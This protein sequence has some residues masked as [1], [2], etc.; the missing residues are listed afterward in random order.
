A[1]SPTPAAAH[2]HPVV[3]AAS[4]FPSGTAAFPGFQ[5]PLMPLAPD[6]I[7]AANDSVKLKTKTFGMVL[8]AP[9]VPTVKESNSRNMGMSFI[10]AGLFLLFCILGLRF[11]NN[12]KYISALLHN[13]V[14]VRERSNV[15]DETVRET[16]FIVLLNLLWSCSAGIVLCALLAY[17]V[18]ADPA[19]SFGLPALTA[20]PALCTA[21]CMGLMILYTCGMALAYLTVGTVFY[22]AL[23]AKMWLKGFCASQGLLAIVFFPLA[24]LLLYCPQWWQ[25]LLWTALG[26]FLI[27]KFVFIWKG[28][29]IFFTQ[30][31]SWVLF[32]YYLCS[33]EI[34]PL[35]LTYWAACQLCSLL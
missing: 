30:F 5:G 35:I 13:L 19:A 34:V 20:K 15:F 32:L 6:S 26:C 33:L 9:E 24:L 12:S 27:T 8:D 21:V 18:P 3:S 11:R 31:S 23:H 16:A 2:A 10:L 29:R 7:N 22:D 17:T 14:D 4:H 1:Q 28:F 25:E